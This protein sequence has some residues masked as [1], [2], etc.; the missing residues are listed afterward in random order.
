MSRKKEKTR[1]LWL[2]VKWSGV[3]GVTRTEFIKRLIE[4][5]ESEEYEITKEWKVRIEWR[6]KESGEMNKGEWQ[7]E[8]TDSRESSPGFDFAVITW[9]KRKLKNASERTVR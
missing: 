7:E 3:Q 1:R 2:N 9:L 8:L 6:N 4:S 5:V